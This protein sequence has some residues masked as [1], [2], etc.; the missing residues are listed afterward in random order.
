MNSIIQIL[1]WFKWILQNLLVYTR[2]KFSVHTR[3]QIVI[4]LSLQRYCLKK[5][6]FLWWLFQIT[7]HHDKRA[8]VPYLFTILNYVKEMSRENIQNIWTDMTHLVNLK[9]SLS[10]TFLCCF[11]IIMMQHEIIQLQVMERWLRMSWRHHKMIS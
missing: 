8:V 4:L 9:I 3:K 10:L 11:Y 2:I 1:Q 6:V 7:K 5:K